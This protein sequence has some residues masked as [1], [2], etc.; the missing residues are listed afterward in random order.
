M[1]FP[2]LTLFVCHLLAQNHHLK[3]TSTAAN[4]FCR[5]WC[6]SKPGSRLAHTFSAVP[7]YRRFADAGAVS[8]LAAF[9]QLRM[10]PIRAIHVSGPGTSSTDDSSAPSQITIELIESMKQ[11]ISE[12]LEAQQ[13]DI[14]DAYGDGRHVSID[15]V[16]KLFEGQNSVKRQRLVYKVDPIVIAKLFAC[17]SQFPS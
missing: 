14:S 5:A 11:K 6:L 3:M 16:S 13:V 12:A 10:T 1:F 7:L 2:L 4:L 9:S 17:L 15:V 8:K